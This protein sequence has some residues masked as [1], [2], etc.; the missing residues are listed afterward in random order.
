MMKKLIWLLIPTLSIAFAMSLLHR[1][2]VAAR[3]QPANVVIEGTVVD[4]SD[5]GIPGVYVTIWRPGPT[6]TDQTKKDG[7]YHFDIEPG[8]TIDVTYYHSAL[9]SASVSQLSGTRN[10]RIGPVI[11]PETKKISAANAHTELQS[12]EHLAV[13]ALL[14]PEH[15]P[16]SVHEFLRGP[17]IVDRIKA[18]GTLE[19]TSSQSKLALGARSTLT[20]EILN[21]YREGFATR[22]PYR[23]VPVATAG[24]NASP[25]TQASAKQR[26]R[27]NPHETITATIDGADVKLVYGRPYT[28]D[29]KSGEMRKIWGGLVPYGK[30]WRMGADEATLFTTAAPI[31]IGGLSLAAGTYSLFTVPAEDGTAKLVINKKTGQWGIPYNEASEKSNELAR[32]DLEKTTLD[33]KVDQFTM[34][35]EP[36][37]GGGGLL[38][39]MWENT[40]YSVPITVKK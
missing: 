37:L 33:K 3:V 30:V 7:S 26:Q 23:T 28:K 36:K 35:V 16:A 24:K 13:L 34:A 6:S 8:E 29:P 39:M 22:E 10:Q 12:I 20:L 38:K 4:Q 5:H 17:R 9:G 32:I 18:L 1:S 2:P 19:P 11:F 31:E 25:T 40:Q 14:N 15:T 27:I 21:S